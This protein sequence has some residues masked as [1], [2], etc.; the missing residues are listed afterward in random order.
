MKKAIYALAAMFLVA[1]G[2]S[3]SVTSDYDKEADFTKYKSVMFAGWEKNSG[4]ILT[5]FDK[6]RILDAL[7][8]EFE[9]RGFT[10]V[11]ENADAA[12]TLFIVVEQ[13]TSTTAYTDYN[14]GMG[15]G[16][17]WGYGYGMGSSTTQYVENNY[18]QGTLIIDFYDVSNKK[19]MWQ[20]IATGVVEEDPEKRDESTPAGMAKLMGEFPVAVVTASE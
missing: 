12:V 2:S 10:I 15:Y 13:K 20:G 7:A 16:P 11:Q 4:Q 6:K 14:G 3:L 5:D 9:K 18:A 19:L 1:C 17:R 8:D